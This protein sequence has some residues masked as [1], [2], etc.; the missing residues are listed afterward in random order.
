MRVLDEALRNGTPIG[1]NGPEEEAYC[2]QFAE[3]LGGG[4]ADAVSSGTAAVFIA[5][6]ALNLDPG[7]EV[8]VGAIGDPGMTM[9][10][11]LAGCV[12][13]VA[14]VAPGS[15]NADRESVSACLTSRTGAIVLAH[16]AGEPADARGVAA[17]AR[18]ASVALIEDCAQAAG[19]KLDARPV[20]TF[21]DVAAFS[22][23]HTK[24]ISTGGQGG[25][26]F[27]RDEATY[28]RLRQH[29]DRGKPFGGQGAGA[30]GDPAI[31]N[32]VAALNLNSDE[33]HAAIGRAQLADLPER[34]AARREAA[35]QI[36]GQVAAAT[37]GLVSTP[38]YLPGAEPSYWFVRL[39]LDLARS[40]G[41]L[42]DFRGALRAEGIPALDD[43]PMPHAMP[44]FTERFGHQRC[45]RASEAIAR[46][47]ALPVTE[48]WDERDT[49][50]VLTALAKVSRA[51]CR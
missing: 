9:A 44:W 4:Y 15:Y 10:V 13:V 3:H 42:E 2:Q 12:P 36:T 43:P 46:H 23:M 45:P 17:L 24:H 40:R 35:H 16:I 18:R 29:A 20:G 19:A 32:V 21:G 49:G 30:P 50:D 34:I 5:V 48:R 47:F 41:G 38:R 33:L 28:W 26:V 14:D 25:L 51:Y 6:R 27:T 11:A 22:T 39:H 7:A 8:V 31:G 37:D 1:Y